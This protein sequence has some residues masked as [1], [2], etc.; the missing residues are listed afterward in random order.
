[1]GAVSSGMTMSAARV[2]IGASVTMYCYKTDI[3]RA[4]CTNTRAT[5]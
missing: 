1:M 4:K 5:K 2:I 3:N